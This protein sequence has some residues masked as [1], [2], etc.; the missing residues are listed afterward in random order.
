MGYLE[1]TLLQ[2]LKRAEAVSITADG[3]GP[4]QTPAPGE[5]DVENES[6]TSTV[7]RTSTVLL[8]LALYISLLVRLRGQIAEC[9]KEKWVEMKQ[10]YTGAAKRGMKTPD[11]PRR[12]VNIRPP[13]TPLGVHCPRHRGCRVSGSL[14]AVH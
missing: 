5:S 13:P 8:P 12:Y 3:P 9:K 11:L 4:S 6:H 1:R 14:P 2:H 7:P 10:Q